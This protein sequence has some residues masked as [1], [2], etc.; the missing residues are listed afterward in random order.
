M[1]GDATGYKRL[2]RYSLIFR[3]F[4]ERSVIRKDIPKI[5]FVVLPENAVSRLNYPFRRP[6]QLIVPCF[7]HRHSKQGVFSFDPASIITNIVIEN[8]K[9]GNPVGFEESLPFCQ[10]ALS[11][12]RYYRHAV[13]SIIEPKSPPQL[14]QG[15][16]LCASFKKNY[17]PGENSLKNFRSGISSVKREDIFSRY[18]IGWCACS[19]TLGR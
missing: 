12:D 15:Q 3:V 14:G 10:I 2:C 6:N 4:F 7:G 13:L 19:Y 1:F 9:A 8:N 5:L 11:S 18:S 16:S 17:C